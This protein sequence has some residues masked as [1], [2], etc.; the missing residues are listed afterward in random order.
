MQIIA[1]KKLGLPPG[2]IFT[3]F[4]ASRTTDFYETLS[5]GEKSLSSAEKSFHP[6]LRN[7]LEFRLCEFSENRKKK[8]GP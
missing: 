8:P 2:F 1:N 3:D 7:F 4:A 6:E 5:L